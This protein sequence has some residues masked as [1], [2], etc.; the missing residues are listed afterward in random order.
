MNIEN[1]RRTSSKSGKRDD[2]KIFNPRS[3]KREGDKPIVNK[4]NEED[5]MD[6]VIGLV[7]NLNT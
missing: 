1:N 4:K 3:K 2:P 6:Q 5:K 7:K